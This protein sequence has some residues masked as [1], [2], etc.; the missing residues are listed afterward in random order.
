M[1][2][3]VIPVDHIVPRADVPAPALVDV[4]V[5][6]LVASIREVGLISPIMVR[7]VQHFVSGVREDRWEI[8]VGRHRLAAFKRLGFATIPA[9]ISDAEDLKAEQIELEENLRRNTYSAAQRAIM[10]KRLKTVYE[11]LHPEVKHGGPRKKQ[12]AD[13]ATCS[14]PDEKSKPDRFTKGTAKSTG[15]SERSISRDA[16]RG[17]ALGEATLAKV[18]GTSLDKVEELDALA[19]LSPEAREKLIDRAADGKK[20]SAKTELKKQHRDNRE[21]VL[22]AVQCALPRKTFGVIVADPEWRF[23]P[24]SRETGMDRA[25][26]NHFPTSC[27]EVIAERDVAAIAAK[28]CVLFLWATNPMLPHALLVMAAWGFDYKSNYCWGKDKAGT[29]YWNREKHELLLVGTRGGIPCPAPGTQWDSLIMAPRGDHSA[30]PEKF[31]EMIEGY[32]PT[33]PKIELNRRGPARPGWAAWGNETVPSSE[34]AE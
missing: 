1:R 4:T 6:E 22:G 10:T 17:E 34:A 18:S 8:L 25:A 27:K 26:D 2:L 5:A 32:F 24:W 11:A 20:V 33:L 31:L 9:V 16:A 28:D 3:E 23:E 21:K 15:Q 7:P 12:V 13:S 14:S 19:K 30:K 29:G